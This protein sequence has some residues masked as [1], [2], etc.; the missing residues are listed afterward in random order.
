MNSGVRSE[1]HTQQTHSD[2]TII[3][4]RKGGI[5]LYYRKGEQKKIRQ[6]ACR[7][8]DRPETD[9][10]WTSDNGVTIQSKDP[11]MITQ[12]SIS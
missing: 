9:P 1:E 6:S 12:Q 4:E 3:T 8:T 10:G 5:P 11:E 2:L 7:E